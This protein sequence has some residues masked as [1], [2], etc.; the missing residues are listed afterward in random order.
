VKTDTNPALTFSI[1]NTPFL[2]SSD[3]VLDVQAG[4]LAISTS[5]PSYWAYQQTGFEAVTKIHE[6]ATLSVSNSADTTQAAW[7]K[8]GYLYTIDEADSWQANFNAVNLV[9]G[10]FVG[11]LGANVHVVLTQ[12]NPGAFG[13]LYNAIGDIHLQWTAELAV[14]VMGDGLD[15]DQLKASGAIIL[16][17]VLKPE[18]F[19]A[20]TA[21][22]TW[23]VV[24]SES[25][26]LFGEFAF[27]NWPA[28][29]W[30]SEKVGLNYKITLTI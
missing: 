4:T 21:T 27:L 12:N 23:T 29:V 6:G 8:N 19:G 16:D 22:G 9:I 15:R 20:A 10:E 14:T 26:D 28:G 1:L 30:S 18:L 24:K 3:A 13:I 5:D 17:G 2:N 7:I 11:V 25:I